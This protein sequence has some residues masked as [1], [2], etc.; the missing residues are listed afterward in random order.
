[1]PGGRLV[2]MV[3]PHGV[4]EALPEGTVPLGLLATARQD[5]RRP[6]FR[7]IRPCGQQ[8][9]YATRIHDGTRGGGA[10][11]DL[12]LANPPVNVPSRTQP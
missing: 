12:A 3:E 6:G 9:G 2:R 10:L 11:T 5:R 7:L 4:N 1:M 8:H